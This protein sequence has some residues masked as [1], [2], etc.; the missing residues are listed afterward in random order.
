MGTR[1]EVRLPSSANTAFGSIINKNYRSKKCV[2]GKKRLDL[3]VIW[4]DAPELIIQDEGDELAK[5][6][7][8]KCAKIATSEVK[9]KYIF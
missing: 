8:P 5:Q 6:E 2:K 9:T 3:S 7:I 4:V 1:E